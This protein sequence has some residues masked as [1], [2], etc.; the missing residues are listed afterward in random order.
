MESGLETKR[1]EMMK[2]TVKS[3]ASKPPYKGKIHTSSLA[4]AFISS[5]L[6]LTHSDTD[7][8]GFW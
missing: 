6:I 5:Q 1:R 3:Q 2:A 4:S 7:F 8:P